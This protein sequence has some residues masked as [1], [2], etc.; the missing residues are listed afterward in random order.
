MSEVV[1]QVAN[2]QCPDDTDAWQPVPFHKAEIMAARARGESFQSIADRL[3]QS[4]STVW[5][6]VRRWEAEGNE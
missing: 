2:G 5:R 6:W 3:D 4:V 1:R